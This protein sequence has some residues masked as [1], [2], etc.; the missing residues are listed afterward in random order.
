MTPPHA[1]WHVEVLSSAGTP[2]IVTL[3]EPGAHGLAITGMQGCGVRTP[4]AAEVAAATCG[5]EGV[6]HRR[7]GGTFAG[8]MSVTT[9]AG[10][11]PLTNGPVAL[12]VDGAVPNEHIIVAPLHTS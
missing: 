9:P 5:F 7:N 2:P 8:V 6:T 3:G 10:A 1:H 12:N 4:R 11:G